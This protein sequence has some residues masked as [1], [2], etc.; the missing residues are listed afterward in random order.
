MI[1]YE[2]ICK[3]LG[4]DPIN[5]PWPTKTQDPEAQY[6]GPGL[7][8]VLTDEESEWL[9]NYWKEYINKTTNKAS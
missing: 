7:F 1:T 4:F 8:D 2:T 5:D 3:K 9:T 6:D